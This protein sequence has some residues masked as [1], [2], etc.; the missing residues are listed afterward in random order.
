[1]FQ[2]WTVKTCWL[3]LSVYHYLRCK[4]RPAHS[5]ALQV[6]AEWPVSLLVLPDE[7]DTL[8]EGQQLRRQRGV[9]PPQVTQ[10]PD[11]MTGVLLR[12]QQHRPDDWRA[13]L[14]LILGGNLGE[15]TTEI[16]PAPFSCWCWNCGSVNA[17]IIHTEI[18]D[19]M[20]HVHPI[21]FSYSSWEVPE[22]VSHAE[23][24]AAEYFGGS[25]E[26]VVDDTSRISDSQTLQ[27]LVGGHWGS[28]V[29][30]NHSEQNRIFYFQ[31]RNSIVF[32][33]D[34]VLHVYPE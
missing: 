21:C 15:E 18:Y 11:Y 16:I 13:V 4:S 28:K 31:W 26:V 25:G 34:D 12:Y 8:G 5:K 9:G 7:L 2:L 3:V 19:L 32:L 20:H 23:E 14:R 22:V 33:V 24:S 10:N 1:M 27:T 17:F 29:K 6:A 30:H